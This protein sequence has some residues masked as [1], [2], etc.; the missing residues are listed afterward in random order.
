[1]RPALMTLPGTSDLG[2]VFTWN[3]FFPLALLP[4]PHIFLKQELAFASC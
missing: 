4:P 3:P 2:T 1:M